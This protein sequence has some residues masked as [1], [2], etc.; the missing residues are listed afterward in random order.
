MAKT[1]IKERERK[2]DQNNCCSLRMNAMFS[3]KRPLYLNLHVSFLNR[4]AYFSIRYRHMKHGQ[5]IYMHLICCWF[6]YDPLCSQMM[7]DLME[8]GFHPFIKKLYFIS[9]FFKFNTSYVYFKAFI[10]GEF[11][12][13]VCCGA[14][15]KNI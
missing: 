6:F 2:A 12:Y 5:H 3:S 10:A 11:I 7:S 8:W 9:L 1:K 13:R 14:S 4:V 15:K